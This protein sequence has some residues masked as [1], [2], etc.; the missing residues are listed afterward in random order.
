MSKQRKTR[1][2]IRDLLL[3]LSTA[4]AVALVCCEAGKPFADQR[5]VKKLHRLELVE[6][7]S[8]S[9]TKL[10]L[11][12][13]SELVGIPV[14]ES[15]PVRTAPNSIPHGP[16]RM[17]RVA[18]PGPELERLAEWV[19]REHH[20]IHR[21]EPLLVSGFSNE[22]YREPDE[23]LEAYR[24]VSSAEEETAEEGAK[25]KFKVPEGYVAAEARALRNTTCTHCTGP[26]KKDADCIWV[27]NKG[28][29]H[30]G[31]LELSEV[32]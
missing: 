31:C 2:E 5:T 1:G 16:L 3:T 24:D 9:C 28:I 21:R 13:V 11:E 7:A 15:A 6:K 14:Q 30:P 19:L 20:V 26:L 17:P 4:D 12:V 23:M 18:T 25:G 32:S 29:F 27:E 8:W 22:T 10:G